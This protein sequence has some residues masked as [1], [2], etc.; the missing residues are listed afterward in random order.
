MDFADQSITNLRVEVVRQHHFGGQRKKWRVDIRLIP[1]IQQLYSR[2]VEPLPLIKQ[3]QHQR[4]QRAVEDMHVQPLKL[5]TLQ[6]DRW[7]I[8]KAGAVDMQLRLAR[9]QT[10]GLLGATPVFVDVD[11]DTLMT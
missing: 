1:G 11:R 10:G 6:Q 4:K 5:G 3:L 2:V 8:P 7:Q 9:R